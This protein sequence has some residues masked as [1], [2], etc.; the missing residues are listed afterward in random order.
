MKLRIGPSDYVVMR[1]AT[2]D[3][4]VTWRKESLGEVLRFLVPTTDL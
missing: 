4:V 1:Q 2:C 3:R